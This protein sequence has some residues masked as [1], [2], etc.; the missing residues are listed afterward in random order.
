MSAPQTTWTLRAVPELASTNETMLEQAVLG[1]AD[2]SWLR[3]DRQ[4]AGRGRRGR[5]WESPAGNLLLSGLIRARPG[6]G[7]LAQLSFVAAL[8]VR[9]A[10]GQWVPA[11][12]CS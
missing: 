6:E 9:E 4:T 1:A 8:A 11:G 12:G 3:A 2:N 7:M 5:V 10:L